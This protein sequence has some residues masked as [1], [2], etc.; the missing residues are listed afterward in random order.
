MN[1][2]NHKHNNKNKINQ[3]QIYYINLKPNKT[4]LF[5]YESESLSK[6]TRK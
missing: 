1:Q 5:L 6:R 3:T 2:S 4:N